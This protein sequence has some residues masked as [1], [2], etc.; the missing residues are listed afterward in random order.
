MYDFSEVW[1]NFK[2]T[3]QTLEIMALRKRRFFQSLEM[4]SFGVAEG[5]KSK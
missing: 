1:V 3:F 5:L 4:G 2:A